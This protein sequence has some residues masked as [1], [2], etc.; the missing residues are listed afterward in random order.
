MTVRCFP[1]YMKGAG[2]HKGVEQQQHDGGTDSSTMRLAAG[3]Q[4]E[5]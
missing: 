2:G 1:A 3:S 5:L 4:A